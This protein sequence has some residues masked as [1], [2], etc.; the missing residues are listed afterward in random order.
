MSYTLRIMQITNEGHLALVAVGEDTPPR[1]LVD[2]STLAPEDA[3]TH[4]AA[5]ALYE[6][7][8]SDGHASRLET[9]EFRSAQLDE[10]IRQKEMVLANLSA[11]VAKVT[12][13]A[14]AAT[15]E[16]V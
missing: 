10:E 11:A 13:D 16:K 7:L 15:A 5:V 14:S 8:F 3:A 12:A 2:A 9:P 1:L 6:R 4:A